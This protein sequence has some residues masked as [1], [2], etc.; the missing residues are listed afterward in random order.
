MIVESIC[1]DMIAQVESEKKKR[2]NSK[3]QQY[4]RSK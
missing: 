3:E 1:V 2:Q 4:L